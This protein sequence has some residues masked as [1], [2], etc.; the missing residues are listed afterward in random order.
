ML[1]PLIEPKGYVPSFKAPRHLNGPAIAVKMEGAN[2]GS[3]GD[4]SPPT[5]GQEPQNQCL[6]YL[7]F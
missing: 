1:A 6:S 3:M 4:G 2:I 7:V 5:G